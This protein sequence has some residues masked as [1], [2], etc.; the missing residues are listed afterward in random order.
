M[1]VECKSKPRHKQMQKVSLHKRFNDDCTEGKWK[2]MVY[3]KYIE[4]RWYR[5]ADPF[6]VKHDWLGDR[7]C[8]EI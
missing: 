1:Y 3:A 6:Y 8:R 5:G 2:R 4:D 7:F